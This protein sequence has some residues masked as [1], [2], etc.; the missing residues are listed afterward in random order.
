MRNR[1]NAIMRY[2]TA[3]C[4]YENASVSHYH[5]KTYGTASKLSCWFAGLLATKQ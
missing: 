5:L 4:Q 3:V 2:S 1:S